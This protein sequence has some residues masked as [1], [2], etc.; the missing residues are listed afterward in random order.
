M[1]VRLEE[2]MVMDDEP[3]LPKRGAVVS[4]VG[5]RIRGRVDYEESPVGLLPV[6]P[7]TAPM[8]TA[9]RV[10]GVITK[11][12]DIYVDAGFDGSSKHVG[13][14]FLIDASP[15]QL[16]GEV[17]GGHAEAFEFQLGTTLTLRGQLDM[18][19]EYEW[20][21]FDLPGHRRDWLVRQVLGPFGSHYMLD[22]AEA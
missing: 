10:T 19:A 22:L 16:T 14:E 21:G 17:V 12:Q 7:T 8:E 4:N 2:F 3:P 5:V 18:I 1:W 11:P 20:E 6:D 13:C 15:L 9:Y